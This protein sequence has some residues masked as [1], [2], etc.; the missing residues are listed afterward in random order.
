MA[1]ERGQLVKMIKKPGHVSPEYFSVGRVAR[2]CG[3]SNSTVLRWI[4][5]GD[6]PAFRLPGGHYRI[7][8]DDF[9]KFLGRYSI[10]A[11]NRGPEQRNT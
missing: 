1:G 4:A 8:S 3:V 2:Q 5:A 6:V 9:E 7:D 11:E 10:P